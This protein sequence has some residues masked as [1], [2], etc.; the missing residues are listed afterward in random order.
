MT[1]DQKQKLRAQKKSTITALRAIPVANYNLAETDERLNDY[2]LSCIAHP[3]CHNLY[4][5]LSITRFFRFLERYEFRSK[6]VKRFV[7]FYERLRFTGQQGKQRYKL[8]PIQVF[9]FANILGFYKSSGARLCRE[10]LLFVPRKFSKT[11]SVASLAIYDLLFGDA[12][13]QAY[14]AAN[15]YKQA[16]IC[17]DEIRNVLKSLDRR[18]RHFKINRERVVNK[19]RGKVSFAECLASKAD[20]L[21]GLNA[22]LV[23]LDEYSQSE[24]AELKNVLTSSM[25]TRLN[26][27]TIVITTA[28]EK[29]D[30]PFVSMLESMKKILRMETEDDSVFAHIFEPDVDD[31]EGDE[32]TWHKVQPHIGI[33][34]RPDY[35]ASE[36]LK[37][38]RTA[39]DMLTF[40]TKMLNIF[41]VDMSKV[42]FSSDKIRDMRKAVDIDALSTRPVCMVAF[43]LSIRDDF[44]AVAYNLYDGTTRRFHLHIDY[45]FPEGMLETHP[46]RE[47]Y[48][49][50]ARDGHLKLVSGNVID[51]KVIVGD[52]LKRNRGVKILQIGYDPY[53]SQECVNMLS[54]AGA[55]DVLIPIKQTYGS[56]TSPV[57][58]FEMSAETGKI[59]FGDNPI[60]WY[61]FGNCLMDE[62]N[63]G[64]RKPI[65]RSQNQ[66]IDGVIAGLMTFW[67]YN[68]FER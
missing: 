10:A 64:N 50:W 42:W 48:T 14:V 33:T 58:S 67:L 2:V 51:Y 23:I 37:A 4:E 18:L 40:R 60:T 44:S 8:T 25:G 68:H 34:V 45:Y 41:A 13:A 24:T 36:Y 27:L 26:P 19:C 32:G 11:T 30:T 17:F 63:N 7:V 3:E 29:V 15:S 21:D 62:D 56:F 31:A 49:D 16:K 47:L 9:Q 35:Y 38:L 1:E 55:Q 6:E 46:N 5:L 65:K 57:E 59:S 22:S 61:C 43:D 53:K 28:S 54:A 39:E 66:K 20:N 52:I 12:N